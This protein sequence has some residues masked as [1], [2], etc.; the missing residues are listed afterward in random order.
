MSNWQPPNLNYHRCAPHAEDVG[1]IE[2]DV[3]MYYELMGEYVPFS[4]HEEA[5]LEMLE[6]ITYLENCNEELSRQLTG[7]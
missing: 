5:M 4:E 2:P 6:R 1:G 3:H 7:D